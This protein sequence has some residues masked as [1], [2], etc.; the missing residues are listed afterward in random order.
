MQTNEN[1]KVISFL[2]DLIC[3]V[4]LLSVRMLDESIDRLDDYLFY[5]FKDNS[6]PDC[7]IYDNH[8][9]GAI[10]D[11]T[12]ALYGGDARKLELSRNGFILHKFIFAIEK[13]RK[14][15]IASPQYFSISK[16]DFLTS[17]EKSANRRRSTV[18]IKP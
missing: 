3:V 14:I 2:N 12:R 17:T 13:L 16:A 10:K 4:V 9:V 15:A 18:K 8:S 5:C 6:S 11:Y 1:Y 7:A